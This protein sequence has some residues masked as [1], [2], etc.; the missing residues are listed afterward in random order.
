MGL[1]DLFRGV[2]KKD[3]GQKRPSNAPPTTTLSAT[4]STTLNAVQSVSQPTTQT[5]SNT[6]LS[7]SPS[8]VKRDLWDE[9]YEALRAENEDLIQK[10]EAIILEHDKQ[11]NNATGQQLAPPKS[12]RREEQLRQIVSQKI[13]EVDLAKWRIKAGNHSLVLRDQFEKAIKVIIATK[14]FIS[15]A[16]SNE[17]HAALAWAGVCVFLPLLENPTRQSKDAQDCLETI[18]FV[19]R[20]LRVM[21]RL[22]RPGSAQVQ[23]AYQVDS[24]A[25]IHDFE[26]SASK[27]YRTILEFQ[28]RVGRQYSESWATRY[29]RDV[30]K[31]DD[32]AGL[33]SQINTLETKCTVL[34]RDLSLEKI[35]ADLQSSDLHIQLGFEQM[36]KELQRTAT[37]IDH[38]TMLQSAWRQ[39]DEE[40]EVVQLFRKGNPYENQKNRIPKRVSETCNWVLE[41]KKFLQWEQSQ[42]PDLLWLSAKPGSGKS[43]VAKTL[44]DERL[45][46]NQPGYAVC[47][48]FFKDIS[49]Y[50]RSPASAMAAILHQLFSAIPSLVR[51]ALFPYEL[52]GKELPSLLDVMFDILVDAAADPAVT[53]IV[54]VMDALDECDEHERLVL[55]EKITNFYRESKTFAPDQQP[56]LKF[57]LTSRPYDDIQFQFHQLIQ[58]VPTIHLSGDEESAGISSEIDRVTIASVQKLAGE[59]GFDQDTTNFLLEK[60]LDVENRTYLWLSLIMDEIRTSHRRGNRREIERLVSELPRSVMDAYDSILNKSRDKQL[61]RELLHIILS[62]KTPLSLEEMSVATALAGDLSYNSYEDIGLESPGAFGRRIQNICGLFVTIDDGHVFLIHQTAKE[63]LMEKENKVSG[64]WRHTFRSNDSETLITSVC[65]SLLSFECFAKDPFPDESNDGDVYDESDGGSGGS[66]AIHKSKQN[67]YVSDSYLKSHPFLDYAAKNWVE[68]CQEC[69]LESQEA[70]QPRIT[71]LCDTRTLNYQ[72]WFSIYWHANNRH[73]P[74]VMTSLNIAAEFKF[75]NI[76][77]RLLEQGEDPNEPD[78]QGAT[79]LQRVANT[80]KEATEILLKAGADVNAAGW[81]TPWITEVDEYGSQRE[82]KKFCGT[83][84]YM[85]I[86]GDNLEVV[87]CLI[88]GGASVDLPSAGIIPLT[89][90]LIMARWNDDSMK[91]FRLLLD[92]GADA[93]IKTSLPMIRNDLGW[94]PLHYAVHLG[95]IEA[96]ELLIKHKN[97][98]INERATMEE[99]VAV[100]ISKDEDDEVLESPTVDERNM[101]DEVEKCKAVQASSENGEDSESDNELINYEHNKLVVDDDQ[102]SNPSDNQGSD[103]HSDF[104]SDSDGDSKL[105]EGEY[106]LGVNVSVSSSASS[107]IAQGSTPLHVAINGKKVK[108]IKLL[109]QNGADMDIRDVH[110]VS[111]MD[112]AWSLF[113]DAD[114]G[115]KLKILGLLSKFRARKVD[116]TS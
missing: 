61:A 50:Q 96:I 70:W 112:L 87:E 26:E 65:I 76:L 98:N 69:E 99:D 35:E 101:Q 107:S 33:K 13:N 40:R 91:I 7:T 84:L 116:T 52:N 114:E 30:I 58:E 54:C 1:R 29:G 80:F 41:N 60:L 77:R 31:A 42:V 20:R 4:T 47:Y 22:I 8:Y 63:Y 64:D 2:R 10:Y 74:E 92:H 94:T 3:E 28:I 49:T 9:A 67:R 18:P 17:P 85:A 106:Y 37:S 103:N 59:K 105:V 19:V 56:K 115:D 24:L 82:V 73:L 6:T 111:A 11:N 81:D 15:T 57:F 72:R 36:Q 23:D 55:I 83:P 90:T 46:A 102:V 88:E 25:L 89:H 44:V 16:V 75:L 43:V 48:F 34:A 51:H 12:S 27:L 32:W 78:A 108:I 62:A 109:L 45:G 97:V 5:T 113:Y 39:T 68:H 53:Q 21:E 79:P 71:T 104:D 66:L 100:E 38:Q 95:N 110:G 14:E 86:S 93:T